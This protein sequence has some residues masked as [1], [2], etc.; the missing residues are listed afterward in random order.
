M[1]VVKPKHDM[2]KNR[3]EMAFPRRHLVLA[4]T[5]FFSL[6]LSFLLNP[7]DSKKQDRTETP[8][9]IDIKPQ[10]TSI[11][12]QKTQPIQDWKDVLI[13]KGDNLSLVFHRVGLN[14]R[15]IYEI[16]NSV[17]YTHLRAHET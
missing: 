10:E 3:I 9:V 8:L 6:A 13:R 17:S 15:D 2:P 1:P 7:T 14:D 4:G 11:E 5:L 12:T 16:I